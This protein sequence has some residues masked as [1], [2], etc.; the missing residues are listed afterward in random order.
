MHVDQSDPGQTAL[1]GREGEIGGL[2]VSH[3]LP[4]T[5][6]AE[7]VAASAGESVRSL[8]EGAPMTDDGSGFAVYEAAAR[9]PRLDPTVGTVRAAMFDDV[10]GLARLAV[11]ENGRAPSDGRGSTALDHWR[12]LF[13]NN[14]GRD[15]RHVTVAEAATGL[16]GYGRTGWFEPAADAPADI[17]P[18][19]WYLTG[20]RVDPD[21]RRRGIARALTEER[22]AGS[23]LVPRRPGT[24]PTSGTACRSACMR[25]SASS[26]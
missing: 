25:R 22:P 5:G 23:L 4:P 12:E 1:D 10:D 20:L 9:S 21:W 3:G 24:S 11:A 14:L 18:A 2:V 15:D 17:A 16:V 19:G 26:R 6:D 13:T 7:A 8:S